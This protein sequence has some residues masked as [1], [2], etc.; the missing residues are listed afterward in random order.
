MNFKSLLDS[1]TLPEIRLDALDKPELDPRKNREVNALPLPTKPTFPPKMEWNVLQVT[2]PMLVYNQN[3]RP[4]TTPNPPR[5]Y[6]PNSSDT[7]P[8]ND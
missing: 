1:P 3:G 8:G 4:N 7:G 6:L 2:D 5:R